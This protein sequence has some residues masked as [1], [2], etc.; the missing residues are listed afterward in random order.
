MLHIHYFGC[1]HLRTK[2]AAFSFFCCSNGRWTASFVL[3][4]RRRECSVIITCKI[5]LVTIG[6]TAFKLKENKMIRILC[7]EIRSLPSCTK[8]RQKDKTTGWNKYLLVSK[9]QSKVITRLRLIRLVI[10]LKT[11]PQFFNQWEAKPKPIAPCTRDLSR[12]LSKSQ[13]IAKRILIGW[14]RCVLLLRLVRVIT[15]VLVFHQSFG[16]R[17]GAIFKWLSKVI[18]RLL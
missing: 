14:S 5:V 6:S 2:A 3:T 16:N 1:A 17:S 11:S 12:A 15:L 13:V 8:L 4:A 7:T 18:P 10:G 9:W